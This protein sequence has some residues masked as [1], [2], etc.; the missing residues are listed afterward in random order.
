[1]C[2]HL[3]ILVLDE[4][5]EWKEQAVSRWQGDRLLCFEFA[6]AEKSWLATRLV[7]YPFVTL[8]TVFSKVRKA[9]DRGG[10]RRV[11]L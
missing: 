1:L 8:G 4:A 3:T 2:E 11:R 7:I 5:G 6:V 10:K 9:L